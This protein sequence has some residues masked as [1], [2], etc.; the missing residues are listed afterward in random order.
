M[1]SPILAYQV[2]GKRFGSL[3]C[4]TESHKLFRK[5]R[6]EFYCATHTRQS[7]IRTTTAETRR[8]ART[9]DPDWPSCLSVPQDAEAHNLFLFIEAVRNSALLPPSLNGIYVRISDE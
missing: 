9:R 7:A 6:I 4:E 5:S 8:R 2:L 3:T 1:H